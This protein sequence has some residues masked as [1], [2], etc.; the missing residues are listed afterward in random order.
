M[1]VVG[2]ISVALEVVFRRLRW[3]LGAAVVMC[4]CVEGCVGLFIAGLDI[5]RKCTGI[6]PKSFISPPIFFNLFHIF[7]LNLLISLPKT[8]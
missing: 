7:N 3:A 8:H 4:V 5:I 1:C 2:I 6:P